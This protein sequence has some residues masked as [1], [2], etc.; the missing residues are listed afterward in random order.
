MTSNNSPKDKNAELANYQT[1][2]KW[3][4]KNGSYSEW[5]GKGKKIKKPYEQILTDLSWQNS[6]RTYIKNKDELNS[7]I[8]EK[9]PDSLTKKIQLCIIHNNLRVNFMVCKS[10][11]K[12]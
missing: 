11:I 8:G 4:Y 10:K 7:P 5:H 2:Q 12:L 9:L 3:N 6:N 1:I